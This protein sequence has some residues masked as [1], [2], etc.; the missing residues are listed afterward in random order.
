[1]IREKAG[2]QIQKNKASGIV[3]G[4]GINKYLII[5]LYSHVYIINILE[6]ILFKRKEPKKTLKKNRTSVAVGRAKTK[7]SSKEIIGRS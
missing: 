6:E 1:L 7:K 4:Y 3:R 5:N 2:A